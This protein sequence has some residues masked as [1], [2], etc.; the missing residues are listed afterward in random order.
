MKQNL[1]SNMQLPP[2]YS[3]RERD[4]FYVP[5]RKTFKD[6]FHVLSLSLLSSKTKETAFQLLN[7]TVLT[8]HKT[9]KSGLLDS[10]LCFRCEESKTMEH[11]LYLA[12]I[13]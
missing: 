7:R 11:L 5:E 4:G 9:F 2:A 8:N 3:T 1:H 13:M 12:P 10:P 6:A